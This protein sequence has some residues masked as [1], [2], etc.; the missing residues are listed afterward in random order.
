MPFSVEDKHTI[1]VL[2]QHKCYEAKR[3][4]RMFPKKR[5]SLGGL[6]TLLNKLDATGSIERCSGSGLEMLETKA[7]AR[8]NWRKQSCAMW[9][10]SPVAET[11]LRCDGEFHMVHWRKL[12]TAAAPNNMQNDCVYGPVG[13][14]KKQIAADQLLRI[15]PMFSQS[16]IVSVGV[17]AL[18]R[19]SIHF[20][21]PG[22]KINGTYYRDVLLKW[23]LL[24]EIQQHS[25]NFTFQQD[26]APAHRASETVQL[27]KQMTPDFIPPTLWPPN[28]P[29]LNPVDYAVWGITQEW[30]IIP[31]RSI[32][33]DFLLDGATFRVRSTFRTCSS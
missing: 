22:V 8:V 13:V 2:R 16:V 15:R 21:D 6:K 32:V 33:L 1:K 18:G 25:D 19:T 3:L 10:L 23:D 20:I 5:W 12:F 31:D 9:S 28:S 4:I 7:S 14:R 27:L 26:G 17:S 24:L 30:S 11:F 29:D